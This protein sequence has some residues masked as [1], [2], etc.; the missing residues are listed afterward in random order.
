MVI[1]VRDQIGD[2]KYQYLKFIMDTFHSF[3]L[4]NT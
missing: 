1:R 3:R 4:Q 2:D